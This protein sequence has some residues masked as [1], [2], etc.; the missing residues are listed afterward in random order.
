MQAAYPGRMKA[1]PDCSVC[2]RPAPDVNLCGG[3]LDVLK[4]ELRAVRWLT[5]QLEITLT[6][7]SREGERN[8]PRSSERPLPFDWNASVDLESLRDG[9]AHWARDI[10]GRRHVTLDA[11]HTPDGYARWL[12][13]W[14]SE[15]TGHPDAGELH[16]DICALTKAARR[17]IDRHPD[18]RFLG[19]CDT[20]GADLYAPVH[21]ERV[22]CHG[23]HDDGTPCEASYDIPSRRAWLL[24]Q[25]ADQL[26]TARQLAYEL[27][28][29]AGIV[30][31]A[32]LIG[33]WAVRGKLTRYLPH[34]KDPDQVT[35]YRVGEVIEMARKMAVD[36]H[37]SVSGAA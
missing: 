12:L 9:L 30:I 10:A 18:W 21:A 29:I 33:M 23:E 36:K 6:R 35:R 8:G 17:T 15:I 19:P 31:N 2:T 27:P 34:A 11:A 28:W 5:T 32:K 1:V 24:E 16:G 3:C 7:Q 22:D 25:A 37:A 4:S 20:C 26:R 14:P 13:R